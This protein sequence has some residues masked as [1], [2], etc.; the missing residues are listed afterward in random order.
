MATSITNTSVTT[1]TLTFTASAELTGT[2]LTIGPSGNII[3]TVDESAGNP[4][5]GIGTTTPLRRLHV[6]GNNT[7]GAEMSL[8]NTSMSTDRKTMN[9]FLSG[10]KAYWRMLNDAQSAGGGGMVE[11]DYDG[12]LASNKGVIQTVTSTPNT[13]SSGNPVNVWTEMNS[14]YRVSITPRRSNTRILG[15]YHIPMNPTGASNIL[16]AIAPWVSSDGGTTQT[17]LSQG[18]APSSRYNLAV[19]WFRSNN[20]FDGNDMQ[21]HVVHFHHDPATTSTRT[22]GFHFRSEGGN[23]TY[24]CHSLGNNSTWGWVAPIYMELREIAI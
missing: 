3:S 2:S 6:S 16:M 8:S 17:R 12:Y 7:S 11:M 14:A 19:S 9:W 13:H 15:T 5:V 20:G 21:N 24:F 22:Y 1:D 10:D 23:T 4:K 18:T